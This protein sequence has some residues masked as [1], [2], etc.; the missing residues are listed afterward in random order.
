MLKPLADYLFVRYV[1]NHHAADCHLVQNCHAFRARG[2]GIK[3]CISWHQWEAIQESTVYCKGLRR[4]CH[5]TVI[6]EAARN[7]CESAAFLWQRDT[8]RRLTLHQARHC[9]PVR[10]VC[11]RMLSHEIRS[12]SC[13]CKCT[14]RELCMQTKQGTS[15]AMQTCSLAGSS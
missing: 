15:M 5:I 9:E 1:H 12:I 10:T 11:M 6:A 2:L 7:S 13:M 8:A 14:L 3:S 4:S